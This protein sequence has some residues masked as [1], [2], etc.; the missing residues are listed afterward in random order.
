MLYF[1]VTVA[2]FVGFDLNCQNIIQITKK[3]QIRQLAYGIFHIEKTKKN[4]DC[5]LY[6][7]R[8][9][10]KMK[11]DVK[12]RPLM[13]LE[14]EDICKTVVD[15]NIPVRLHSYPNAKFS[16]EYS[17]VRGPNEREMD[18]QISSL[19]LRAGMQD[20]IRSGHESGLEMI[21]VSSDYPDIVIERFLARQGIR[22][23]FSH[24]FANSVAKFDNDD[25]LEMKP[26]FCP[27]TI[28]KPCKAKLL[29][30]FTMDQR[31]VVA[32]VKGPQLFIKMSSSEEN[33]SGT[34]FS[35]NLMIHWD[36]P[37]DAIRILT[38]FDAFNNY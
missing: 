35:K 28:S 13:V 33:N 21:L 31:R 17:F 1:K 5:C 37:E 9:S 16:S 12:M 11:T 36:N 6:S 4:M 25:V 29:F 26:T 20:L 27:C 10:A 18:R 34:F 38:V 15:H 14:F 3:R 23:V 22:Q 19:N 2:S 8:Y 24:V 7:Y 32:L 30:D